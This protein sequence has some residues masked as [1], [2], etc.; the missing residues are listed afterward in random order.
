MWIDITDFADIVKIPTHPIWYYKGDETPSKKHPIGEKNNVDVDDFEA[1]KKK[2]GNKM[3]NRPTETWKKKD[4]K[5]IKDHVLTKSECE[6]LMPTNTLFVKHVPNLYIVD[7]DVAE[8]HNMTDFI[9]ITG[10]NI[11]SDCC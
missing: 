5:W 9:N 10:C 11:F 8:I 1:I 2:A 4:D 3:K 7:V 6:T